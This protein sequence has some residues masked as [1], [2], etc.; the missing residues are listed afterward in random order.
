MRRRGDEHPDGLVA[1]RLDRG[2]RERLVALVAGRAGDEDPG[3]AVLQEPGRRQGRRLPE[4][5]ADEA[6]G[7]GEVGARI[8][9]RVAGEHDQAVRPEQVLDRAAERAQAGVRPEPVQPRQHRPRV[10][11][12]DNVPEPAV[13]EPPER[14]AH[15]PHAEAIRRN[16]APRE[17]EHRGDDGDPRPAGGLGGH[18]RAVRVGVDQQ[19]VGVRLGD[20]VR[21]VAALEPATGHQPAEALP[22]A[23]PVAAVHRRDAFVDRGRAQPGG[24][25]RVHELRRGPQVDVVPPGLQRKQARDEWKGMPGGGRGVGEE[26]GHQRTG[27]ALNFVFPRQL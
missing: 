22:Q 25:D 13:A 8:L 24:P 1:E 21:E 7:A 15:R 20:R 4:L 18:R 5:R 19:H 2:G 9:E 10:E 27:R 6:D 3:V 14:T 12:L 16:P 11:P 17:G 26:G 23:P